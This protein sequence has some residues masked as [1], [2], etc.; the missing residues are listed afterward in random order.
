MQLPD[1]YW[2]RARCPTLLVMLP[3]AVLAASFVPVANW[4]TGAWS[5]LGSVVLLLLGSL[6]R[7]AGGAVNNAFLLRGA[8]RRPPSDFAI[9]MPPTQ[10]PSTGSTSSLRRCPT[11]SSCR[12]APQKP[13]IP[14]ARIRHTK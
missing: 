12:I 8:E 10:P 6:G 2:S 11:A 13:L 1:A 14:W 9:A 7:D 5:L 3:A 4:P